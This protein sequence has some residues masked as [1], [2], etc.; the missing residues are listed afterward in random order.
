[1]IGTQA[2]LLVFRFVI[3]VTILIG[4]KYMYGSL[5]TRSPSFAIGE[6]MNTKGAWQKKCDEQKG[7][8][9]RISRFFVCL[10]RLNGKRKEISKSNNPIILI[11][12]RTLRAGVLLGVTLLS[13]GLFAQNLTVLGGT[14]F[15]VEPSTDVNVIGMRKGLIPL[16]YLCHPI[17][18]RGQ[19]FL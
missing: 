14:T 19:F 2:I 9:W 5:L 10:T 6:R 1:M 16:P 7:I 18:Y 15:L 4:L 8:I 12:K 13:G 17:P 3:G 11:M